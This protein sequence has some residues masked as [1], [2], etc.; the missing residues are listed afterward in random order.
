MASQK[1]VERLESA[2]HDFNVA[3]RLES[4]NK[5]NSKSDVRDVGGIAFTEIL[6]EIVGKLEGVLTGLSELSLVEGRIIADISNKRP[7]LEG[8][9]S[10]IIGAISALDG[11]EGLL[12]ENS[13]NIGKLSKDIK[14]LSSAFLKF[15]SDLPAPEKFPEFPDISELNM[16]LDKLLESPKIIEN[17]TDSHEKREW[18]FVVK[19]GHTG[20]IENV[21]AEEI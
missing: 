5:K 21:I 20:L 17:I 14:S 2:L 6:S 8:A 13:G 12:G 18:N 10:R 16:K 9:E 11:I 1:D 4:N 19:R 3:V 7:D 15:M